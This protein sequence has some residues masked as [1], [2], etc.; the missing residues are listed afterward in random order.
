MRGSCAGRGGRVGALFADLVADKKNQYLMIDS[1]IVRAHQQAA[2]AQ[3]ELEAR[4]WGVP[5]GLSTKIHLLADETGLPYLPHHTWTGCGYAQA[6]SCYK[7][8]GQKPD[9]NKGYD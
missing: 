5:S 6:I 3:R 4:L 1:T 2:R 7:A 9:A 8:N